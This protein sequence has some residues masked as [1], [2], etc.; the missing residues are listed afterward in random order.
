VDRKR[1]S[2]SVVV[3]L[4][5]EEENVEELCRRLAKVLDGLKKDYEIVMVDDGS[6]DSTLARLRQAQ[7]QNPAIKIVEFNRNYGQHAAVFAGFENSAGEAVITMDGDLQNPPEEIVKIVE[8]LDEGFEVVGTYRV[9][10][11]DPLFRK[12]ASRFVTGMTSRI[13]GVRLKDYGCMLRGYKRQV[14]QNICRSG[15]ISTFI[16]AL[17]VLF[18]KRITEVPVEHSPRR[19]GK[20]KYGLFSLINLHFDLLTSISLWPL[21]ALMYLGTLFAI[22]GTGFGV[23]L[24]LMRIIHWNDPAWKIPIVVSLFAVLF[25]FIGA[26]FFALGL[27]GEYIG[28]IYHEARKRPRYVIRNIY[29]RGEE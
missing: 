17:A 10:R 11:K 25:L 14:V 23:F 18:A 22:F 24:G 12:V 9:A 6:T 15:E 5:D 29:G 21:R 7:G 1:P 16:P 26:Q 27:L 8:K 13:T 28:R 4:F 19:S 20:S 2:V 3:P